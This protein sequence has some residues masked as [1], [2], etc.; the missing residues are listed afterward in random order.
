M[1]RTLCIMGSGLP[2]AKNKPWSLVLRSHD[3]G[4]TDYQ[5]IALLDDETAREVV[6]AGRVYWLYGE[7]D[8]DE[9]FRKR[10]L[11]KA[12][13]LREEAAQIEARQSPK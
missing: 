1:S 13:V 6:E 3:L 9:R 10:Q 8:W 2:E 5:T 12:R 4:G 7:P 11:E